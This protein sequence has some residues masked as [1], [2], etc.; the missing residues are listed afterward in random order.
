MPM[1]P[2]T[3]TPIFMANLVAVGMLG[4]GTVQLAAGLA[5][6]TSQYAATSIIFQSID[7][8]TLGAGF[9]IGSGP[10]IPPSIIPAM[11]ASFAGHGIAGPFSIPTATG[12]ANGLTLAFAVAIVQTVAAGVG[13]GA[14][15]GFCIPNPGASAGIYTAAFLAAG[16][17]GPST[18]QLAAAV[19]AG[20]D[21]VLPSATAPVAIVGPPNIVPGAGT[22]IGKLL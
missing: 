16:M 17:V 20:L 3:L 10:V 1:D 21:A 13:L 5:N 4:P 6:G 7:A 22:G 8:G 11:I 15:V 18:P 14:G 19:A 2:G 9:G 12:I